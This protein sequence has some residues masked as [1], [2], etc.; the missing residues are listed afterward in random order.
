MSL[1]KC[2]MKLLIHFQT[3]TVESLGMNK[4]FHPILHNGCNYLSMLGFKLNHVSKR[5]SWWHHSKWLTRSGEISLHHSVNSSPPGQN[6]RH[7]PDNIFKSIF[8]NEKYCILIQISLKFVPKGLIDNKAVLVQLM[9][10]CRTG[11]KPLT[12][13]ML[14][15][16]TDAY[17]QH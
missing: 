15:Q 9:A 16:F 1:V 6:G 13:P 11:E 3:A 4:Q 17:M 8:I 14:T 7:F 5:C 10:W 2:E 12:E